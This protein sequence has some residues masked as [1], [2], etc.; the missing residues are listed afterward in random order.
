[1]H[2]DGSVIRAQ[3]IPRKDHAGFSH[4][5]HGGVIATVLDEMMAWACGVFA[6]RFAYSV[7]MNIRY[8]KI[9][10]PG[11]TV[12]CTGWLEKNRRIDRSIP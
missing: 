12:E 10:M 3:W 4:A 8:S 6:G 1:M 7:D 11:A 5:V 2:A 9:I